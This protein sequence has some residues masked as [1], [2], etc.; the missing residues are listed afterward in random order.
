MSKETCF[1][2][3]E[4]KKITQGYTECKK[5]DQDL[6]PSFLIQGLL[7]VTDHFSPFFPCLEMYL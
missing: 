4:I 1:L 3:Q 5:W 7:I 2:F 6:N